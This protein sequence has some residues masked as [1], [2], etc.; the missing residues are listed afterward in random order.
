MKHIEVFRLVYI[1]CLPHRMIFWILVDIYV[2]SFQYLDEG[3]LELFK[4]SSVY[5][6]CTQELLM[7]DNKRVPA[8]IANAWE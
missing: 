6:N 1:H 7:V 3:Y 4:N 2:L 5:A 8:G